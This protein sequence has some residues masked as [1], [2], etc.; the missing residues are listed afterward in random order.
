MTID[1]APAHLAALE[2]LGLL[3]SGGDQD[4]AALAWAVERYLDTA[5]SVQ[6]IGDALYRDW[7]ETQTPKDRP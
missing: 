5:P 2:R 7:E 1:V 6:G 4:K 3:N